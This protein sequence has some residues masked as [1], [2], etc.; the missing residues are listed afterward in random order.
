MS[1]MQIDPLYSTVVKRTHN[2]H[3]YTLFLMYYCVHANPRVLLHYTETSGSLKSSVPL[4]F[5]E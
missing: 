2:T 5:L 3:I 1:D 4:L